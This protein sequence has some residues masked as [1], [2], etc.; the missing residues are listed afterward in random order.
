MASIASCIRSRA[1]R[2]G[3]L[4]DAAVGDGDAVTTSVRA[5]STAVNPRPILRGHR[6]PR[7]ELGWIPARTS[8][9]TCIVRPSHLAVRGGA[10]EGPGQRA[11]VDAGPSEC[12]ELIPVLTVR[13]IDDLG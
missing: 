7:C 1:A 13:G 9:N 10:A 8:L 11:W 4:P 6:I 12:D 3:Q 2:L 5:S